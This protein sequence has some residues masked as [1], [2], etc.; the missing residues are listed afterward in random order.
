MNA[1]DIMLAAIATAVSGMA[2]GS[3]AGSAITAAKTTFDL[4]VALAGKTAV[5]KVL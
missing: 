4:S 5:M 1:L 2:G 3:A